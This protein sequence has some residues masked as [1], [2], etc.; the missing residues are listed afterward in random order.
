MGVEHVLEFASD[1]D[2]S[3]R[4][5]LAH[6]HKP[7]TLYSNVLDRSDDQVAAIDLYVW[8]PPCQ[9]F[10]SAGKGRGTHGQTHVGEL[11]SKSMHFIKTN[12]PRVTIFENV[13]RLI[14]KKFVHVA[15]GIVACQRKLGYDVHVKVLNSKDYSLPQDRRRV[16][17]VG[18]RKDCVKHKFGFPKKRKPVKVSSILDP[19]VPTDKPGLLPNHKRSKGL[20]V[21]AYSKVFREKNIDPRRVPIVVDIDCSPGYATFGIEEAKTITKSRG[22]VGGPWVSSRGRRVTISE[23]MRLQGFRD[24]DIPMKE[25]GLSARQVGCMVG[26]A[27]SVNTMGCL[28]SEALYS[29]GLTS[30]KIEFPL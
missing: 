25:L 14:S 8:T 5:V 2:R 27:V 22:G 18:V 13:K 7:R 23:L 15:K 3:C 17:V 11:M 9:D 29:A 16:F 6:V 28:L 24:E 1:T 10:S 26:N 4:K 12:R 19:V 30:E 20:C 21:A